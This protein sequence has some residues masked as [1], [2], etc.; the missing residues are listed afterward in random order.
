[1]SANRTAI[2]LGITKS[3][4]TVYQATKK[5]QADKGLYNLNPPVHK[6][7]FL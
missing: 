2:Q 1:M 5:E 7:I 3:T 6:P 4:D